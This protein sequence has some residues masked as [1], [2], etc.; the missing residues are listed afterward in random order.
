[1][2]SNGDQRQSITAEKIKQVA[3]RLQSPFSFNPI[4]TEEDPNQIKS[5]EEIY[6]S[7]RHLYSYED[8][9]IERMFIEES[10]KN[11]KNLLHDMSFKDQDIFIKSFL[12]D[13]RMSFREIAEIHGLSEQTIKQ[14]LK[15]ITKKL[16]ISRAYSRRVSD[17]IP[18]ELYGESLYLMR[19]FFQIINSYTEL[20]FEKP[21]SEYFQLPVT[22]NKP[23]MDFF[24]K[25]LFSVLS[26]LSFRELDIFIT[27]FKAD[28]SNIQ[29]PQVY[30]VISSR[31][32]E[33][34]RLKLFH[35][36]RNQIL[37]LSENSEQALL[38]FKKEVA[39]HQDFTLIFQQ[40]I[41]IRR[42]AIKNH[43]KEL[44]QQKL[45]KNSRYKK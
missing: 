23:V 27:L 5:F 13:T 41:Q 3:L 6:N 37:N 40:L 14:L 25:S 21:L 45:S 16:S 4:R 44:Q 10:I 29:N 12:Q 9:V 43:S 32:K 15:K 22:I 28:L 11:L 1:M 19:Q 26:E 20:A 31:E 2:L 17:L 39:S 30:P 38:I 8:R 35:R 18:Q 42:F 24:E 36:V 33:Q 7:D 34:M